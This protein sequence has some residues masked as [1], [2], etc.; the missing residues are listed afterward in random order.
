M[1]VGIDLVRVGQMAESIGQFGA[2]FLG[3]IFTPGEI[4][5]CTRPATGLDASRLAARFAAKEAMRKV[6][7]PERDEG[8]GWQAIEICRT[9]S[10]APEIVLHGGARELAD[11]AG[12]VAFSVSFT[13][14]ADYASA[15]VLG[16]RRLSHVA[17]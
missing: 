3:R 17:T 16:E 1:V 14:E 12:L 6:L 13:H 11:R 9:P 4:A 5:D 10:G 2:R 8:L 7:R 15:V